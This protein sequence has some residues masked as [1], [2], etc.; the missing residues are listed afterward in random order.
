MNHDVTAMP[1]RAQTSP[2]DCGWLP[3]TAVKGAAARYATIRAA[4]AKGSYETALEQGWQLLDAM[5][6]SSP[7]KGVL[8]NARCTLPTPPTEGAAPSGSQQAQLTVSAV[9][10][11]LLCAV[12]SDSRGISCLLETVDALLQPIG[13]LPAWMR[14]SFACRL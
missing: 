14:C 3:V 8:Q 13:V 12:Q 9:A 2:A 6:G 4:V 5:C 11:L 10:N 1:A 7:R